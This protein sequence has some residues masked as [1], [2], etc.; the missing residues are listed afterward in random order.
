M[1]SLFAQDPRD[2]LFG[3][4]KAPESPSDDFYRFVSPVASDDGN[5]SSTSSTPVG[6]LLPL[7]T[8]SV[9]KPTHPRLTPSQITYLADLSIN[10]IR[11]LWPI[12]K[13]EQDWYNTPSPTAVE[14]RSDFD[15]PSLPTFIAY[16]L[17]QPGITLPQCFMALHYLY[18]LHHKN[19]TIIVRPGAEYRLFLS[20]LMTANKVH[21]DMRLFNAQW[22]R[23]L[24]ISLAEINTMEIQFLSMLNWD[25][26][27]SQSGYAQWLEYL[28][29]IASDFDTEHAWHGP[30]RPYWSTQPSIECPLRDALWDNSAYIARTTD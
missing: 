7:S 18:K 15:V 9:P 24:D 16:C 3:V 19:K 27:M 22:S 11:F 14:T 30:P 5:D 29:S 2:F 12:C 23:I 25:C 1:S 10:Y 26:F 21:S 20:A 8:L 28:V 13:K 4:C 17:E 6:P